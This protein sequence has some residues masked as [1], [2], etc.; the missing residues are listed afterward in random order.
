M[1]N[2]SPRAWVSLKIHKFL[3]L[4]RILSHLI[5]SLCFPSHWF[6]SAVCFH[7]KEVDREILLSTYLKKKLIFYARRKMWVRSN[8]LCSIVSPTE[9]L[10]SFCTL[11]RLRKKNL[12]WDGKFCVLMKICKLKQKWK[13]KGRKTIFSTQFLITSERL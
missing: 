1:Q 3:C 7:L 8:Q 6:F 12:K 2:I 13:L 4:S 11:S 9:C 10:E 5:K